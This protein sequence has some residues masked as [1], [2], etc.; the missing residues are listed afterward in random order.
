MSV[1]FVQGLLVGFQQV[2]VMGIVLLLMAMVILLWLGGGNSPG[3]QVAR[4][5][6]SQCRKLK[7]QALS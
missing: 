1:D 4:A 6:G 2:A 7:K 3:Q 5:A